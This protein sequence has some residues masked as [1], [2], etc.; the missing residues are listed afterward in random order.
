MPEILT[1]TVNP[2]IDLTLTVDHVEPDTKLRA[3]QVRREPGGGGLNVSRAIS[4]LGGSSR[5]IW[6]RGGHAGQ[7]LADLLDDEEISHVAVDLAQATRE[8]FVACAA[9]SGRQYRFV[10][11]GPEM[12]GP[13]AEAVV[14]TV[15]S[16]APAGGYLVLSGSVPGRDHEDLYGRIVQKLDESIRVIVDTSGP[17]LAEALQAGVWM[18]KP[19]LAELSD[20]LDRQIESDEQIVQAARSLI[21]DGRASV[22]LVSLGAG[23]SF[24]VTDEIQSHIR[25]PTVPIRSKVGAGD[26]MVAGMAL[27]LGRDWPVDQAAFLATATGAAAVMTPGSELCRRGDAERLYNEIS[28][29]G[30]NRL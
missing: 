21:D 4:S 15:C 1:V 20:L 8:N 26:S 9:G 12:T 19:N 22:V 6:T 10:L 23:G 5:A 7:V 17:A 18:F 13:E 30:A 28:P 14:Q 2:T 24:L 16:Q 29:D 3:R 27:G 11:P 25:T